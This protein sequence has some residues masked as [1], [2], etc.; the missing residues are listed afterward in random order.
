MTCRLNARL[1][2]LP[3]LWDGRQQLC[4]GS[5]LVSSS[6]S[7]LFPISI[8]WIAAWQQP[9]ISWVTE[10]TGGKIH[11]HQKD[12]LGLPTSPEL[13]A[14]LTFQAPLFPIQLINN[15]INTL[16]PFSV[17]N[18]NCSGNN[19]LAAMIIGQLL[20]CFFVIRHA[21]WSPPL[22]SSAPGNQGV[23]CNLLGS[24]FPHQIPLNSIKTAD[25]RAFVVVGFLP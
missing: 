13:K 18:Y 8:D 7:H 25:Y 2:S 3:N 5:G 22:S 14:D 9:P 11:S 23:C 10:Y 21:L 20:F 19:H 6:E 17:H 1:R 24:V 15:K 16:W 12:P 4:L